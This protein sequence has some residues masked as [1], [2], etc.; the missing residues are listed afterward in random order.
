M[1]EVKAKHIMQHRFPRISSDMSIA[2]L[3]PL[4]KRYH[5]NGVPV[6]DN[7]RLVGFVSEHDCLPAQLNASY[8]CEASD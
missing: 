7:H 4:L 1:S 3:L 6:Q 5:L 2:Q 8:F